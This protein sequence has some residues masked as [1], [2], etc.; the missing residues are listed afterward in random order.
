MD[1][2]K[3]AQESQSR[4]TADGAGPT[5][6]EQKSQPEKSKVVAVTDGA[7]ESEK[8]DGA[9]KPKKIHARQ[10]QQQAKTILQRQIDDLKSRQDKILG[11]LSTQLSPS[12]SESRQQIDAQQVLSIDE[13]QLEE[14]GAD[15]AVI[16]LVK[17]NK[18]LASQFAELQ[19]QTGQLLPYV[20]QARQ[21]GM[22]SEFERTFGQ[23][24]SFDDAAGHVEPAL[25]AFMDA[26]PTTK[27]DMYTRLAFQLA[28]EGLLVEHASES[29]QQSEPDS[30]DT[31][32]D[33]T[34]SDGHDQENTRITQQGVTLDRDKRTALKSSTRDARSVFTKAFS[35][36]F[37]KKRTAV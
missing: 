13:K 4:E 26:D 33:E 30:T 10:A 12:K 7:G 24:V 23:D 6:I 35:K 28:G 31:S 37:L 17:L 11:L 9:G 5:V 21:A 15:P 36:G 34:S 18:Q 20:N 27:A 16:A 22:R 3:T 2:M 14:D 8:A 1:N 29:E 19:Q 32:G 25:R